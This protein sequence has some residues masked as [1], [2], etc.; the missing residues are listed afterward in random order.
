[1]YTCTYKYTYEDTNMGLE[2]GAGTHRCA[3]K[4]RLGN[5]GLVCSV[6]SASSFSSSL[7]LTRTCSTLTTLRGDASDVV[8]VGEGSP[9]SVRRL[10]VCVCVC[11]NIYMFIYIYT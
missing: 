3:Q 2:L 9:V 7:M 6:F 11:M 5:N 1:M 8:S 10:C 4:R